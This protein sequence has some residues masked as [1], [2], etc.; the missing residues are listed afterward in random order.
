MITSIEDFFAT[1]LIITPHMDEEE[2][3]LELKKQLLRADATKEF[4]QGNL[5]VGEFL[6]CLDANGVDPFS[7]CDSWGRG[8]PL[9]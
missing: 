7:A 1:P 6:E 2:F 5:T 4:F 8:Q 3:N 9:I